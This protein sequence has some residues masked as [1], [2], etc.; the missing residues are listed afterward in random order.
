MPYCILCKMRRVTSPHYGN[1]LHGTENFCPT[2]RP[3]PSIPA[4]CYDC[5]RAER[6]SLRHHNQRQSWRR[7]TPEKRARVYDVAFAYALPHAHPN[8]G[9]VFVDLRRVGIS[10]FRVGAPIGR[11]VHRSLNL[12]FRHNIAH[13][14]TACN[15]NVC[16]Q[17]INHGGDDQRPECHSRICS[18]FAL[19]AGVP[20]PELTTLIVRET[21][22]CDKALDFSGREPDRSPTAP[23]CNRARRSLSAGV[24]GFRGRT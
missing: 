7:G 17:R 2:D 12:D 14:L 15:V 11:D 13:V 9:V 24:S 21:V 23:I 22:H 16:E 20:L 4:P 6:C 10:C 3:T 1:F 5:H 18:A 8:G 19:Y